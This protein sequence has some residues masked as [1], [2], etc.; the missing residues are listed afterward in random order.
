MRF[1]L[2]LDMLKL[3][4]RSFVS[5]RIATEMHAHTATASV[6]CCVS[7]LIRLSSVLGAADIDFIIESLCVS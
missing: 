7:N 1:G 5:R 4:N 3:I 6:I 2:R